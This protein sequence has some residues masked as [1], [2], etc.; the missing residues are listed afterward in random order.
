MQPGWI[1]WHTGKCMVTSAQ[2][3]K[4][5]EELQVF[6]LVNGQNTIKG[7]MRILR[8]PSD[9]VVRILESLRTAGLIEY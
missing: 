4:S 9:A 8:K 1:P 5:L 6:I 7:I 2:S 3:L